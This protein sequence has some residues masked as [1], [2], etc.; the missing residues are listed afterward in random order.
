MS[1][2]AIILGSKPGSVVAL[3]ALI[4][5]GWDVK[6]V[7]ASCDESSPGGV[8]TLCEA[9]R[10]LSI[11][12]HKSQAEIS[13][14]KVDLV[15][16]YMC[17]F[18]VSQKVI[19]MGRYALNFHAGPLPEFGGWAFYNVAILEGANEYG[20][21]C[22]ILEDGF[23]EGEIIEVSR[24]SIDASQET[25][26]SLERKAQI[27]MIRLFVEVICR[28]EAQGFLSS[29]P[30]DMEKFRYMTKPEFEKLKEIGKGA[31]PEEIDRVSRA[32]WFPPHPGAFFTLDNGSRVESVPLLVRDSWP[33]A[34]KTDHF[35]NLLLAAGACLADLA[36]E[37]SADTQHEFTKSDLT[38]ES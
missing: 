25:A 10:G 24:F 26:L 4:R 29:S 16:S 1:R 13:F 27:Q 37:V 5:M 30:Q 32:F 23:D 18:R 2:S 17:R 34:E 20:C 12:V 35:A 9:A 11:P 36:H 19:S 7:V 3:M 31:S 28:Y 38:E 15:I 22:H 6:S 21:T 8:P 33:A 14:E